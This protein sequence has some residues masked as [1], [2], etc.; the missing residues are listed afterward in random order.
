[1]GENNIDGINS[2][3]VGWFDDPDIRAIAPVIEQL[4]GT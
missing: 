3:L 2:F 1:M 4:S